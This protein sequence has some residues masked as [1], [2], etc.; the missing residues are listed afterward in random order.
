MK[1]L[2]RRRAFRALFLGQ[3]VSGFGDWMVTV[4][5]MALVLRLS[6]SSTAVGGILLLRLLPAAAAASLAA[7]GVRGWDGRRTM[8]AAD[9]ARAGIVVAIPLVRGVWWVYTWAFLLEVAGIVFLPARDSLIP[10]LVDRDELPLAN[11]V[12]LASSYGSIPF[13]A[14]AFAAVVGLSPTGSGFIGDHPFALVFLVDA[15]TF[16]VSFL[17]VLH[18][19]VPAEPA[20]PTADERRPRFREALRIPLVRAVMAPTAAIVLALGSLFSLGVVYVHD[21]LGANDTEFGLL[22]AFFGIGAALGLLVL[23]TARGTD[24]PAD[25]RRGVLVQGATIGLM[26]LTDRVA[27]AFVGAAVFGGATAFVIACGMGM[28]QTGLDGHERV[29]AFT[30]FHIVIRVGLAVSAI[31]AGVAGDLVG[32]VRLPILGR[33]EPS[34]LVLLCAGTV[35]VLSA[36]MLTTAVRKVTRA[37]LHSH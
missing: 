1:E 22:I 7:R 34:R 36:S 24:G 29:L 10:D 4:A 31:G 35:V 17:F 12:I 6:G 25:L 20:A 21:V 11:G 5:M 18:L 15:V 32:T 14:A 30:A 9:L 33:L 27:L 28:V 19:P 2:L 16:L 26:S 8:L 23:Q 3:A 37:G 13:G